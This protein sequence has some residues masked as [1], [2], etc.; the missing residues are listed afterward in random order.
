M[1]KLPTD[2]STDTHATQSHGKKDQI[3]AKWD[4]VLHCPATTVSSQPGLLELWGL[5]GFIFPKAHFPHVYG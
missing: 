5:E 3:T 4:G 1:P 2:T